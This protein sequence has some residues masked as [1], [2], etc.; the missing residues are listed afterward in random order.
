M[1]E[2][3]FSGQLQETQPTIHQQSKKES[4]NQAAILAQMRQKYFV[5]RT[6]AGKSYPRLRETC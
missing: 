3:N 5:I 1:I 6:Q 2:T 4:A